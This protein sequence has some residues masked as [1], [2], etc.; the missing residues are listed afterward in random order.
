M[1]PHRCIAHLAVVLAFFSS[2]LVECR[3]LTAQVPPCKDPVWGPKFLYDQGSSLLQLR[4]VFFGFPSMKEC[5]VAMCVPRCS[6]SS[7]PSSPANP[8]SPGQLDDIDKPTNYAQLIEPHPPHDV[9]I[10]VPKVPDGG[11]KEIR[12]L[13]AV[14]GP[15]SQVIT[16]KGGQVIGVEAPAGRHSSSSS[17]RPSSQSDNTGNPK[18]DY[19]I[20]CST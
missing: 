1:A 6:I 3:R 10:G 17:S 19:S 12:E 20:C 5:Q 7:P 16:D 18:D 8:T 11:I 15:R 9:F 13:Q 14:L 4:H 2:Q